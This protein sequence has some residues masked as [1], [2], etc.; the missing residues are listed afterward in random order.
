MKWWYAEEERPIELS[1][2]FW[3]KK[4]DRW[5]N[6]FAPYILDRQD[7]SA[8]FEGGE[9]SKFL[10]QLIRDWCIEH[11]DI[12][13]SHVEDDYLGYMD[14]YYGVARLECEDV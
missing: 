13:N 11:I 2:Y 1:L 8:P 14:D 3:L 6:D 12:Y 9:I 5:S 7:F 10:Y 4:E